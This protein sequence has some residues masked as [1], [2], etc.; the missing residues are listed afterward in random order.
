ME[1]MEKSTCRKC[2]SLLLVV[3]YELSLIRSV[4]TLFGS[5]YAAALTLVRSALAVFGV[6]ALQ[7]CFG[8]SFLLSIVLSRL[9]FLL[10]SFT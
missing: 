1:G 6:S 3:M 7:V 8:I 5:K 2:K 9:S 10:L 4:L